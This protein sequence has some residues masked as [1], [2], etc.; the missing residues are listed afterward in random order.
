MNEQIS[1]LEP[2]IFIY[3]QGAGE[4]CFLFHSVTTQ[5]VLGYILITKINHKK[6][7]EFCNF[8]TVLSHKI[9]LLGQSS[10]RGHADMAGNFG[11]GMKVEINLLQNKGAIFSVLTGP[12]QWSFERNPEEELY[13]SIKTNRPGHRDTFILIENLPMDVAIDNM[14]YLFFQKPTKILYEPRLGVEFVGILFYSN[15]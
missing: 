14:D 10:K 11:E 5:E 9:L 6:Y 8:A 4:G 1:R 13:V 15:E 7:V 2:E 3:S 12:A